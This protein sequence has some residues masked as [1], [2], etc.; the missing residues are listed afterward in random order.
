M[1]RYILRIEKGYR[2]SPDHWFNYI[3]KYESAA[4]SVF[5]TSS[6]KREIKAEYETLR[7]KLNAYKKSQKTIQKAIKAV[8]QEQKS[9]QKTYK[10]IQK[11]QKII[12]TTQVLIQK[13]QKVI[14]P[15]TTEEIVQ[16][17]ETFETTAEDKAQT[18]DT[19]TDTLV[20]FNTYSPLL[21]IQR[22]YY[23]IRPPP[24]V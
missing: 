1:H 9:I 21:N 16:T 7:N 17:V 4:E 5:I 20:F 10:L 6:F 12:Q 15:D 18:P 23:L 3:T 19:F 13:L 22:L 11:T 14:Q 2:E 8:Q 24:L